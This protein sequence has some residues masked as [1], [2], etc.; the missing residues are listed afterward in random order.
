MSRFPREIPMFCLP[1]PW[2][3][4]EGRLNRL[5]CYMDYIWGFQRI[6]KRQIWTPPPDERQSHTR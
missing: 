2:G 4:V 5:Y 3:T 1:Y 6:P